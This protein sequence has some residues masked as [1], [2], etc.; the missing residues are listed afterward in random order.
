MLKVISFK[1]QMSQETKQ[2]ALRTHFQT[3]FLIN[4]SSSLQNYQ[5]KD[6]SI[7]LVIFN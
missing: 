5:I 4:F 7:A 1:Y 2:T 3:L 6:V